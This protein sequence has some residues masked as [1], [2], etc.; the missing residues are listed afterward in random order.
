M[1][2]SKPR[3][4][5]PLS[6]GSVATLFPASGHDHAVCVTSAR[7]HAERVFAGKGIRMTPLRARVLQ[8]VCA[9]HGAI[10]AYEIVDR[11]AANGKRLAPIS[12][13]RALDALVTAGVVHRLESRNAFFACQ[14]AHAPQNPYLV[15]ICNG[16]G[17]VAEAPAQ[18]VWNAISAAV[19]DAEFAFEGSLIEVVGRCGACSG[20]VASQ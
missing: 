3:A 15:L 11:M 4:A 12:V 20:D 5:A 13:Y 2:A 14:H 1:R 18:N 6:Q 8:E 9:S 17:Q 7:E 10:G 19:R 16:C